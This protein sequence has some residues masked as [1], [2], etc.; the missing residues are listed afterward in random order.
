[1]RQRYSDLTHEL[2]VQAVLNCFNKKWKRGD[3]LSVLEKYG[4]VPRKMLKEEMREQSINLR[5]EAVES[6]AFEMEQRIEYLLAG[7]EDALD[8]DNVV[9]VPRADGMTGK[10]RDIARLCIMHQLFGHLLYLG[11]KPLLKARILPQQFASIP[12]RGQTGLKRK[13][14]KCMRKKNLHIKC[15]VKT[16]V[17]HAYGTMMYSVVIRQIEKEIPSAKWI[18]E[19]L[20]AVARIAPGGHLII[21]GYLDA[22][23]FNLMM[24]YAL[25]YVLSHKAK[26]RGKENQIVKMCPSY[27]DDFGLLG[28]RMAGLRSVARKLDVWLRK[29]YGVELKP[30]RKEVTILSVAEEKSRR[31][32]KGSKHCAPGLDMGGYVVHRTYTTIRRGI[33]RRAR[34]QFLR[35]GEE[36]KRTGTVML[37]RARYLVSYNGYFKAT[38]TR[39][40]A[41]LLQVHRLVAI[42]KRVIAAHSRMDAYKTVQRSACK[43]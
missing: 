21:G 1:M 27:M 16:D 22:W 8:L 23:L 33:Y 30:E 37:Y 26:R 40:A 9:I 17:Y 7:D 31:K 19:V 12:G 10:I 3:V 35:A 15:A 6:L 25:R 43:C 34:R 29:H 2:C 11:L 42:A 38:D 5:L 41:E 36:F 20:K 13:I 39:R 24:S 18:I 4:G 32:M 14:E 28:S